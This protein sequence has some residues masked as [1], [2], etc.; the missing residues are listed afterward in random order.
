MPHQLRV[1]DGMGREL[2]GSPLTVLAHANGFDGI[3]G[4]LADPVE[5]PSLQRVWGGFMQRLMPTS[6]PFSSY[7]DWREC[8]LKPPAASGSGKALLVAIGPYDAGRPEIPQHDETFTELLTAHS[9]D[10]VGILPTLWTELAAAL[11]RNEADVVVFTRAG[12][13]LRPGWRDLLLQGRSLEDGLW[14]A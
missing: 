8:Y 10:C 6:L 1:L 2:P 7:E 13:R 12:A 3:I 9:P 5:G 11:D 14:L 4:T